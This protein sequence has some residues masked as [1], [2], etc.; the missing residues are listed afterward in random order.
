MSRESRKPLVSVSQMERL[1]RGTCLLLFL[2]IKMALIFL[3]PI[4]GV[5]LYIDVY[6]ERSIFRTGQREQMGNM[7]R[8]S[9]LLFRSGLDWLS[10]PFVFSTS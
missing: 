9:F 5:S 4:A 1:E 2:W 3:Y 10:M 7:I 6:L 8:R